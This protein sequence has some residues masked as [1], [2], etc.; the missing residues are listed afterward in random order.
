MTNIWTYITT[1]LAGIIAGLLIFLKFKDPDQVINDNQQIGKLKQRGDGTQSI[2]L[3]KESKVSSRQERR[4][5]RKAGR[6]ERRRERQEK[7]Q[8]ESP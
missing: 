2:D 1:L 6:I 3:L 5:E 7:R 4:E 8:S